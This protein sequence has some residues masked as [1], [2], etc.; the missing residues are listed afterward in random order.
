ML[1]SNWVEDYCPLAYFLFIAKKFQTFAIT[2]IELYFETSIL[3]LKW[4]ILLL[5]VHRL[6][7][8]KHSTGTNQGIHFH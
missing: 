3:S 8:A 1:K 4:L 7:L 6:N 5:K 2:S